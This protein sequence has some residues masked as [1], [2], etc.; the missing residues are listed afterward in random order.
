MNDKPRLTISGWIRLF[1]IVSLLGGATACASL[2]IQTDD[3]PRPHPPAEH[4]A[5]HVWQAD[6]HDTT[7]GGFSAIE[8]S[9]DGNSFHVLS[10]RG[11]L[12]WGKVHRD[13]SGRIKTMET[14]GHT[15]L[16]GSGGN[17]LPRGRIADSEGMAIGPDGALW[18]SF[19]GTARVVRYATPE[20][21]AQPLPSPPEFARMQFNSSLEALAIAD[22]GTI[23]TM[24]ERSGA[25]DRPFPVWRYRNGEW[26]QPFSIQRQGNWLAVGADIGPDGR[27]YLLE[28]DFK[29]LLGFQSRVRRFDIAESGRENETVLLHTRPLQ[30]DNLE[31]ISVW[32]DGAAIRLTM[33]SDNNF[34][35]FQRN[36]I[37]EFRLRD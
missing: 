2:A 19:E 22:D 30:F 6:G 16:K 33:I 26:E 37:V 34:N 36:E 3:S 1:A 21:A 12:R 10:D 25:L 23:Y 20:S 35:R 15:R 28:R 4:V 5:T 27:F 14:L 31:G 24:P 9:K 29:G 8:L 7:F 18:I 13:A 32:N 11:W 17:P